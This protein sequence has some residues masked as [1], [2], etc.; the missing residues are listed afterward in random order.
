MTAQA[1]LDEIKKQLI[2][3]KN[4]G[5]YISQYDTALFQLFIDSYK[6]DYLAPNSNPRLTADAIMGSL[7]NDSQYQTCPNKTQYNLDDSFYQKWLYWTEVFEKGLKDN[8]I[9]WV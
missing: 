5:G 2:S 4:H 7:A 6:K 8:H 9:Q 3:I 1:N